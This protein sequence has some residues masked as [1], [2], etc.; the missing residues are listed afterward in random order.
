ML[1]KDTKYLKLI[2]SDLTGHCQFRIPHSS[3][4]ALSPI[5]LQQRS[6]I[7]NSRKMEEIKLT[8]FENTCLALYPRD[9]DDKAESPFP[10]LLSSFRPF[11]QW[12]SRLAS[13]LRSQDDASH[14]F[15]SKPYKLRSVTIQARDMFG[16]KRIGFLKIQAEVTN[17]DGDWLPGAVFLRGTSVAMLVR[18]TNK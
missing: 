8:E 1:F 12:K 5:R 17:D 9:W 14:V 7:T 16:P 6:I 13:T 15:H 18:R 11:Q 10:N 4:S 2:Q 3:S